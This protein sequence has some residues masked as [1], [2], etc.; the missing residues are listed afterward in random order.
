MI[1]RRTFLGVLT[2]VILAPAFSLFPSLAPRARV[3]G[4]RELM[5]ELYP[6]GPGPLMRWLINEKIKNVRNVITPTFQFNPNPVTIDDVFAEG[7]SS[8]VTLSGGRP[9]PGSPRTRRDLL[10][11]LRLLA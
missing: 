2:G 1:Q 11:R 7:S 4:Y 5:L 8:K 3:K 6:D 9:C 10:P